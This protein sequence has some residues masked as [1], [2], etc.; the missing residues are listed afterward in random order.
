[1]RF[2]SQCW[3]RGFQWMILFFPFVFASCGGNS[4]NGP[5]VTDRVQT[6]ILQIQSDPVG[7]N[8]INSRGADATYIQSQVFDHLISLDF[9]TYELKP[10]LAEALPKISEDRKQMTF[11]LR[12]GIA[13][14]DG[15]PI[16]AR[17]VEFSFKALKNPRVNSAPKR[18]ELQNFTDCEVKDERT[19]VFSM[20]ESGPFDLNRLA[21]NFFVLPKHIYDPNNFTDNYSALE[22]CM[23]DK[24]PDTISEDLDRRLALFADFFETE[25]FQRDKGFVIG[26]G[27]YRFDGWTTGQYIRLVKNEKYWNRASK[28]PSAQQNMDTLLYKIIPQATT[29]LQALKSGEIDFSDD[30]TPEQFSEKMDGESFTK[31][32]EK[33]SV[34]FPFYEYMGF[35]MNIRN[36]PRKVFFADARVRRA[37]G[38]LINTQEIIDNILDGTAE[39]IIS[40]V[41]RERPEYNDTLAQPAYDEELALSLLKEAGWVDANNDGLLD[42]QVMNSPVDFEFTLYYRQGNELRQRIARHIQ[43]K[44]KKVGIVVH[45]QDLEWSVM[46]DRLSRHELD[47][48]LGGWV[49]DSDEQDL[50]SLFHSSQILNDGYNWV[51]YSSPAADSVMEA[52]KVEWDQEKRYHLHRKIQEILYRDQP[53]N[54]LFANSARIAYNKRLTPGK[55]YGQRPCYYPGEFSVGKAPN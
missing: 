8:P 21:I 45:I 15:R 40:M 53:Y 24:F 14:S 31:N 3:K 27:R 10:E 9:E 44:L 39:P 38:H 54:L 18:S 35:N 5:L 4:G 50:Y 42:K 25:R 7:M 26:S 33:T 12:E 47:A 41:Y 23:A 52:I 43:G 37:I 51:G 19:V 34:T 20:A 49:Y 36:E 1:M 55:W 29:A 30:F 22:A 2:W 13:F 46:L 6:M 16:T 17:D 28:V 48:W 32:F 11:V